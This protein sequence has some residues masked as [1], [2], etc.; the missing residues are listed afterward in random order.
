[1]DVR[2][3]DVD[4]ELRPK[5]TAE[6]QLLL[7]LPGGQHVDRVTSQL[8]DAHGSTDSSVT[9]QQFCLADDVPPWR[10]PRVGAGS[11]SFAS[12]HCWPSWQCWA[13]PP[14]ASASS[15]RS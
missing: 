6:L 7:Q 10:G 9:I 2:R 11:G 15:P 1:M 3:G 4:P 8:G 5:R 13:W 14:S 12:S